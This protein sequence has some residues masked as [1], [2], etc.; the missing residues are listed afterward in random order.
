MPSGI[1]HTAISKIGYPSTAT[2]HVYRLGRT[3]HNQLNLVK[4]VITPG[5]I[6]M[7]EIDWIS[8]NPKTTDKSMLSDGP[9]ALIE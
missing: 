3:P 6:G 7:M 5:M 1:S 9:A 8:E 4:F 2:E